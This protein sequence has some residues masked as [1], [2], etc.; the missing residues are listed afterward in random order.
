MSLED[1][2]YPLL[3][4]YERLPY[5]L[6]YATGWSY[7]HLPRRV[8]LGA[9]YDEFRNL[10]Q[11]VESWSAGQIAE[12]QISQLRVTLAHAEAHSPFYRRR[13]A[14]AAFRPHQV[15]DFD[16]LARCPYVNKQDL[17]D[18]LSS[19][20]TSLPPRSNRLYITTGGSTGAPVGFYLQKGV[21]RPKEHAFLDAQWRRA[22]YF[23]GARLAVMRGYVTSESSRDRVASYDAARDWL[24]LSSYHLT[25]DRLPEYLDSVREFRPDILHA[26]PSAALQIA[27]LLERTGQEWP[28]PLRCV[29]A[30]SERL[31]QP[32]KRLLQQTFGCRVYGWYGHSERVVLAAEGRTSELLYFW[33]VYGYVEFGSP[34]SDGF[35]E[36]IGTSFHNLAMPLIRYRTGDYVRV[37]DPQRDGPKEF[38]WPAVGAVEGREHE[39]LVA[40]TGRKIS[41]TALNMHD[42]TFDGIYALQFV[43]DRPGI[44]ELR[45]VPGPEFNRARLT[46]IEDAV[47]RKLGDDFAIGFR[48]VDEVE[49]TARGKTKWLVSTLASPPLVIGR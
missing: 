8:R 15:R 29:L 39:F 35:S 5:R 22:G 33:P 34:D 25:E 16:D 49:K 4:A 7:R 30:G 14:E 1:R 42:S 24:M 38:D 21:S 13:F 17:T 9:R 3:S 32:Q 28:V 40:E 37:Y 6:K 26:Y 18:E 11:G 20:A 27:E 45:Y 36:I 10:A 47:R 19:M 31:T 41:L 46:V 12:Y 48:A 23:D 44:A 43:Q 2:F